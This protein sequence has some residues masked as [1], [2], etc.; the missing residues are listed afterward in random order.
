[1]AL[2]VIAAA[3]RVL[4]YSVDGIR[5]AA[6]PKWKE[7]QHP[8]YPTASRLPAPLLPE[9]SP[10]IPPALEEDFP[11]R[12]VELSREELRGEGLS[13]VSSPSHGSVSGSDPKP[14][15]AERVEL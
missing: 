1:T 15:K 11:P 5:Y 2:Q 12:V 10:S 14:L 13:G 7:H 3:G 4:L 9:S 8:K 6:F